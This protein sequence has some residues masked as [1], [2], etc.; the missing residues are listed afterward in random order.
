MT[1]DLFDGLAEAQPLREDIADGAALLRL[2]YER[3]SEVARL[4]IAS[5][6]HAAFVRSLETARRQH[7]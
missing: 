7:P 2:D 3:L 4:G 6:T 1:A 5:R